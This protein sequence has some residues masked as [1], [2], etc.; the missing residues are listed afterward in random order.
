ML[1]F[2]LEVDASAVKQLTDKI[3]TSLGAGLEPELREVQR[4]MARSVDINF[5]QQGRPERWLALS[6][7]TVQRRRDRARRR[8]RAQVAG[9][10]TAL[11][12]T[13]ELRRSVT[14]VSG[15]APFSAAYVNGK[16][17]AIGSTKPQAAIQNFGGNI[18]T[19]RGRTITIPARP[20]MVLQPGDKR[21]IADVLTRG[22]ERRIIAAT[23]G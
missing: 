4:I 22:V 18:T 12:E 16:E 19:A 10:E 6:P 14:D 2:V 13:D 17:A 21:Q 11:Q 3:A 23:R 8:G 15:S 9:F 20:F 7:V 1:S 5:R